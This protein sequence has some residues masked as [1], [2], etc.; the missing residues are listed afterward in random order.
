MTHTSISSDD[1]LALIDL[2]RG[3]EGGMD[4]SGDASSQVIFKLAN[5]RTLRFGVTDDDVAEHPGLWIDQYGGLTGAETRF[6]AAPEPVRQ[7]DD[8]EPLLVALR[9]IANGCL[10]HSVGGGDLSASD[11]QRIASNALE[12]ASDRHGEG[13]G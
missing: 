4:Y 9:E 7:S 5:G 2:L 8:A 10:P 11:A 13:G 1:G 6:F 12:R 3:M